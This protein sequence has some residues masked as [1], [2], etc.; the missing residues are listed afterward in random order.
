MARTGHTIL[1]VFDE[2]TMADQAINALEHAGFRSE[3]IHVSGH[4]TSGGFFAGLKSFFTGEDADAGTRADDFTEIGVSDDEAHYYEYEAQAGHMV[5]AVRAEGREQ[6]AMGIL[7]RY[8]AYNYGMRHETA[9]TRGSTDFTNTMQSADDTATTH[10]ANAN[11]V[12]GT[13]AG[14]LDLEAIR[15]LKLR[16]EQLDV[17]KQRVQTGGV[18]LRKE[19]VAEQ[20]TIDVPVTHEEA[21]IEHRAVT[22]STV[23]DAN[24]TP[25]GE[26][27]AIR[28][29][30]S[31]EQVNVRKDTVVTGEVSIGKR[32]VEE[33]QQV[34]DTVR[35]EEARIEQQGDAPIH[36][37]AS[38]RFHPTQTN[39]ENL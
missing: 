21:Y 10:G 3:Q 37:T 39:G 20:Q 7:H 14:A 23:E 22:D 1:G 29:P 4:H 31:N 27:E 8:G 5:V 38:D 36:G 16:E 35:R 34:S 2:P 17:K 30:L 15:T 24:A 32:A 25:I 18:N 11:V 26:G 33:T 12:R 28:I 13:D 19:V 6:E 9:E